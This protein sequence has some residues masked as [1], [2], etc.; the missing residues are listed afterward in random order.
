MDSASNFLVKSI[1]RDQ[2]IEVV[3]TNYAKLAEAYDE[4]EGKHETYVELLPD[5]QSEEAETWMTQVQEK[6][7]DATD[8]KIKYVEQITLKE[9]RS[10][11]DAERQGY[12][13]RART[14]RNTARAVFEASYK[15]IS[16][17][18]KSKE[19]ANFA[20]RDLQ[21]QI[22]DEFLEC[23]Q[24]NA[25]LLQLL[26][27]ESAEAEMNWIATIQ[28][29]YHEMKEKIVVSYTNVE[30]AKG[31]KQESTASASFLRLEKVRMLHFDAKL[32]E[33]P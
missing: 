21:T 16:H 26:S 33:Y 32:R 6:F 10:R 8:R 5:E 13:D 14:K 9:R 24:S 23:K 1:E 12:I 27:S 2:G 30:E 4:L 31:T 25:E 29:C 7:N 15:S 22:E 18:L 19:I 3:E 17:A 28:T 20:L 11:E